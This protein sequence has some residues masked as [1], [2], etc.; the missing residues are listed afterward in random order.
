M[1]ASLLTSSQCSRAIF[2]PKSS[3]ILAST[4]R[5]CVDSAHNLIMS[6][7][8]L[9]WIILSTTMVVEL[10][11]WQGWDWETRRQQWC[12]GCWSQAHLDGNID[13]LNVLDFGFWLNRKPLCFTSLKFWNYTDYILSV[14]CKTAHK[15]T[16]TKELYH[17]ELHRYIMAV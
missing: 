5:P 8:E 3:K 16:A 2:M 10:P 13:E 4:S 11:H 7:M 1:P 9:L 6:L 14:V 15:T 17:I 12:C